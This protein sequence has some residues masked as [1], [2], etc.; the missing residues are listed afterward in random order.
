[1]QGRAGEPVAYIDV[2]H[3]SAA[4]LAEHVASPIGAEAAAETLKDGPLGAL[5]IAGIAV[6]MLF[7]SWLAFYFFL[8]LPR[9]PVG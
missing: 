1:M 2:P 5:V 6:G 3:Q 9:G 7:I 8:F 4:H